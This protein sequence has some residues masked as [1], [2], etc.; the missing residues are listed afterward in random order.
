MAKRVIKKFQ[1]YRAGDL[2]ILLVDAAEFAYALAKSGSHNTV[3][4]W[5]CFGALC[6]SFPKCQKSNC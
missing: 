6:K 5:T 2:G 4:P 1:K 3:K